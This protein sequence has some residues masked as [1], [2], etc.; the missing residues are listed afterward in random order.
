MKQEKFEIEIAGQKMELIFSPLAQQANGAV[1]ARLGETVVLATA[2]MAKEEKP[3]IDYLPLTVDFEEKYYAAGKIYGSR[4]IRRESRPTENAILTGRLID[5]TIRPRFD[6][7]LRHDIQ[8]IVTCLSIDEKNDPD[9]PAIL[10]ASSALLISDIPWNGPVAAARVGWSKESGFVINPDY[11]LRENLEMDLLVSGTRE[12]INMLEAQAKGVSEEIV[13]E[14]LILA[15]EQIKKLIDFQLNLPPHLFKEKIAL[16]E[17]TT[18]EELVNWLKNFL[19]DKLEAVVYSGEKTSREDKMF[20]LK[21]SL[22]EALKEAGYNDADYKK[23]LAI[24]DQEIDS[25]VHQKVLLE[26]KRPDGRQLDE[27]RPLDI[28]I[29]ILPRAHGSALFIRGLTQALSVVT[30]G[31]PSDALTLQGMEMVG[32]KRFM[33]HYN[34][35]PYCSGEVGRLGSPGRR[36]IGHGALA[37]KALLAVIPNKEEFPYTIRVVTEILSSNGSTSMASVCASSL[38]LMAAGVP[39]KEPVAGIAM[40]LMSDTEGHYKIL[41]DIQGPED[42]HGDMDLKAAGTKDGLTALQMDVKIEGL[43][44]EIIYEALEQAKKARMLILDKMNAVIDKPRLELSSYAPKIEFFKID[45]LRIG[46][47]IGSGGRIINRIINETGVTID[48]DEEGYVYIAGQNESSVAKAK[49]MIDEILHEYKAGEV[50]EG[51]VLEIRDF[52]AIL[53]LGSAKEGL[54]HISELRPYRVDKVSDI[55]KPG[56]VVKV[57]IKKIENGKI[58]LS[59]KDMMTEKPE[60]RFRPPTRKPYKKPRR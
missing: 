36:E 46:E 44:P 20:E 47:V 52:G 57:K 2:V 19:A 53:S 9:L 42:H 26:G 15:Q 7:N 28:Y 43:S 17:K 4:F 51:K 11:A 3:E 25:L 56:D 31:T 60:T 55:L 5:R 40:G 35:P 30:L 10:A 12:K 41:T 27:V 49:E 45:P 14:G 8:I 18:S 39:I 34:F 33:H 59:L 48:I 22:S 29:D 32:T 13:K 50:V 54:L 37:E 16:T 1:L 38:A 23:A 24:L 58:S 6:K 21:K